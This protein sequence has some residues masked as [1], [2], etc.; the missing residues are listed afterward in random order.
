MDNEIRVGITHGDYNGVGYEVTLGALAD[1]EMLELMT[2]V[3]YGIPELVEKAAAETGDEIPQIEVVKS[4]A[5]AVAGVINVVDIGVK[6]KLT[7]GVPSK[8]SGAAAVKA[9]DMAVD[10]ILNEEIDVLVTAPICKEAVQSK[11]FHFPGHTEYLAERAGGKAQ[12]ILFDDDLRVAL[13]TTHLPLKDIPGSVTEES[14]LDAVERLDRSLREDFGYECPRI[15][16]LGLN[17]HNG[18]GGLLGKEELEVIAPAIE[19]AAENKLVFGPF[20]ADGFFGSGAFSHYDGVL[21]MYH[22]QGLAPFKA[23][24]GTAGVNF[25]AGLPFVRTSPDHGTAFDLAWKGVADPMSMRHAI[26]SAIDIYRTRQRVHEAAANPLPMPEPD[27]QERKKAPRGEKTEKN[28]RP[29]RSEKAGNPE[30]KN[31]PERKE[32]KEEE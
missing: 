15:A 17:P 27:K 14:I 2:P 4:A 21:A 7:P 10:D 5:D 22:D 19:K 13:L 18:D 9:L 16:V 28:E 25:T 26:Y 20:A 1:P 24:A 23:V 12:M 11:N 29:D 8:E 3:I 6:A 32:N 30:R 31:N